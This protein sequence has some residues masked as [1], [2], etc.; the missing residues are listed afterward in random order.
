MEGYR[1]I[2]DLVRKFRRR[3][4]ADEK[5]SEFRVLDRWG[6][7]VGAKVAEQTKPLFIVDGVLYVETSGSSWSQEISYSKKE[8]VGKLNELFGRE[9]I[10]DI[11]HKI[12]EQI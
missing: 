7:V 4:R 6:E 9:K 12:K 5:M 10:S 1:E 8:I 3:M 2:G 11:K